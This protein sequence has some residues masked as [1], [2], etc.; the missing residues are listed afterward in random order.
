MDSKSPQL[1]AA[2]EAG[3]FE[4]IPQL[5]AAYRRGVVLELAQTADR[6]VRRDILREAQEMLN[7][8]L[9]LAKAHRAR[10]AERLAASAAHGSAYLPS[11]TPVCTWEIEA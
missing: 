5:A 3:D 8:S 1:E 4:A 9:Q 7:R 2:I 6:A 10:L 11:R